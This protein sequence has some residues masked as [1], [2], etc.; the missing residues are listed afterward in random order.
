M[1][2][3]SSSSSVVGALIAASWLIVAM[4]TS[5]L[6]MAR[7]C[8]CF[9]KQ[10]QWL[11]L[12][13]WSAISGPKSFTDAYYRIRRDLPYFKVNYVTIVSLVLALR[14]LSH[15]LSLLVLM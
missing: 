13:D 8:W 10:Q 12:V 1:V 15:H 9:T 11:E 4:S 7:G 5:I 2:Q 6:L 14:L 3:S